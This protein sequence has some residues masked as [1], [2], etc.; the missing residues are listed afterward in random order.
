MGR[1]LEDVQGCLLEERKE[2]FGVLVLPWFVL[3]LA[4]ANANI[5]IDTSQQGKYIRFACCC[6]PL[7]STSPHF[8]SL[9]QDVT[10][11][12]PAPSHLMPRRTQISDTPCDILDKHPKLSVQWRARSSALTASAHWPIAQYAQS[13]SSSHKCGAIAVAASS[14]HLRANQ[15]QARALRGSAAKSWEAGNLLRLLVTG[16]CA[17]HASRNG[18]QPKGGAGKRASQPSEVRLSEV[19]TRGLLSERYCRRQ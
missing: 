6:L 5:P 3:L 15:E 7:M 19:A 4:T 2:R 16:P 9:T 11:L 14:I 18:Q 12:P 10:T 17:F 8:T 13:S 1:E